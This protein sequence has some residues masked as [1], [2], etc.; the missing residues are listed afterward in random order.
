MNET[1]NSTKRLLTVTD[2]DEMRTVSLT[3]EGN[4]LVLMERNDGELTHQMFGTLSH[5]HM[6]RL[7]AAELDKLCSA[8]GYD[9]SANQ[10]LAQFF[11]HEDVFLSDLLD[12]LDASG[13]AYSYASA[14]P[15]VTNLRAPI[16]GEAVSTVA[17]KT[18]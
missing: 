15:L 13:V 12:Q 8:I 2:M 3:W 9:G 16:A 14:T 17:A 11:S 4:A 7:E 10:G 6:V 5:V 1:M 18:P